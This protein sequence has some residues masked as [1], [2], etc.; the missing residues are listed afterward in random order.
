MRICLDSVPIIYSRG[1]DFRTSINL[2]KELIE[3]NTGH[4]YSMLC[5]SRSPR[6]MEITALERSGKISVQH[7]KCPFSIINWGW[8]HL[9]LPKLEQL[10]GEVDLY[11]GTSI[12]APPAKKAKIIVTLHGIVAEVIPDKLPLERVKALRKVL[13]DALPR[14]D[15][16]IAVS[17]TTAKDISCYLDIDPT[18]IYII[19]HGVDPIFHKIENR[20]AMQRR[21]KE[22]FNVDWPYI[23]YVGAIGIHK[24]VL[25][26]LNAYVLLHN[27][28][29]A[30]YH[31][32]L[33]GKPD[34]AWSE[35][36]RTI[37]KQR[38]ENYVHLIGWIEPHS[39][40]LVDFYNGS[41]CCAFPSFYEGWCSPPVEAMA[42]GSPVIASNVSSLPETTGGAALLVDPYSPSDIAEGIATV[43]SE[44]KLREDMIDKGFAHSARMNWQRAAKM[45]LQVYRN[46]GEKGA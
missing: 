30:K 27:Q 35:I 37:A 32:C 16:L 38:L 41:S 33:V 34:S 21:L 42:C 1:A 31:L 19:P 22:R 7:I 25:G 36:Q 46:I 8:K 11:H 15:Y 10:L 40:D 17:E 29:L 4:N 24:N 3:V 12:Y 23:L 18:R 2:Y 6:N 39:H 45:A 26:L 20:S 9:K 28:G 5:I 43:L 44:Q 13:R 14:T